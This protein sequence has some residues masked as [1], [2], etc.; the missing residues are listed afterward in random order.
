M[1]QRLTS[2][3]KK[4]IA[5]YAPGSPLLLEACALYLDNMT[6][7]CVAQIKWKNIGA[8]VI[9]AVLI[10]IVCFDA[11]GHSVQTK[12]Y[13][14]NRLT[15]SRGESFG[16]KTAIPLEKDNICKY[17][18]V[19]RAISYNNGLIHEYSAPMTYV[20][21]PSQVPLCLSSEL[22]SQYK[23][24]V[25]KKNSQSSIKGNVQ[26]AMGL[27]QCVCGSWQTVDEACI[28]CGANETDLVATADSLVLEQHLAEYNAEQERL[29]EE[30]SIEQKKQEEE[31]Q[32]REQQRK[33]D[34]A[35]AAAKIK[36]RKQRSTILALAC[37]FVVSI[38]LLMTLVIIPQ[39]KYNTATALMDVSKYEEAIE[40]FKT[41]KDFSDSPLQIQICWYTVG[42]NLME[43]GRFSEAAQA[44]ESASNYSDS[45]LQANSCWY[46]EGKRL[47]S[48]E[49]W[50]EAIAAFNKADQYADSH[51]QLI[52]SYQHL[53]EGLFF[54]DS[55][56]TNVYGVKANGRVLAT[57]S[58]EYA[59]DEGQRNV[60]HFTDIHQIIDFHYTTI[61]ITR[62]G[63][64]VAAGKDSESYAGAEGWSD[65]TSILKW[66]DNGYTLIGLKKD[67]TIVATGS[68]AELVQGWSN[69]TH[70]LELDDSLF[71]LTKDGL[72]KFIDSSYPRNGFSS[73]KNW[74]NITA[75]V[76]ANGGWKDSAIFGLKQDGTVAISGNDAA[77][78]AEALTWTN[79][80]QLA[81][82]DDILAGLK[83]DGTVV[84]AGESAHKYYRISDWTDIVSI[85]CYNYI[86]WGIK[87]DGSVVADYNSAYNYRPNDVTRWT[88]IVS[89]EFI[90]KAVQG[91]KKDG[92]RIFASAYANNNKYETK[93]EW[94]TD[95]DIVHIEVNAQ[96][97][98]ALKSDGTVK[99]F[100]LETCLLDYKGET[101]YEQTPV[102]EWT[103]IVK[104]Y[105]DDNSA[106]GIKKDGTVV[107]VGM[108]ADND[109]IDMSTWKLW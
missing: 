109:D 30:A 45:A 33:D 49:Q 2:L 5:H 10:D 82:A 73:V 64:L 77:E 57:G 42:K 93:G 103:D 92:G 76:V 20:S 21:L 36:K 12:S 96:L 106:Y 84:V 68:G 41:L 79:I 89:L 97:A 13:Q 98:L 19:L 63:V 47:A 104:I 86:V 61:G 59:N 80:I 107:F 88:D 9:S 102:S 46:E 69:I 29:A 40:V 37:T 62:S 53:P 11:F 31:A 17:D 100:E 108:N 75:I 3:E 95:E 43:S 101:Q 32:R 27:W 39:Q 51:K 4:T 54:Q 14:Y 90:G 26:H 7:Q 1:E 60:G 25:A 6:Q 91:I 34:E 74:R 83:T 72:V 58:E 56:R 35:K 24:D 38:F 48:A 50:R 18:V 65:V 15:T 28:V 22:L 66:Y 78:Y 55:I 23:R 105:V 85:Y 16:T 99:Y 71:G 67:G 52:L 44:F 87:E 70:L 81:H 8:Q 94:N